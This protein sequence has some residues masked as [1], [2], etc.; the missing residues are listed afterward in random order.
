MTNTLVLETGEP[1]FYGRA[2][3]FENTLTVL[4]DPKTGRELYLIGTTNSSTLLAN[5]TKKLVSEVKPD[6]VIVQASQQWWKVAKN[7]NLDTQS[8]WNYIGGTI[9]REAYVTEN[10]P[11][12]IWFRLKYFLWNMTLKNMIGK[13]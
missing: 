11:R 13:L 8:E 4:K 6:E 9:S 3:P 2:T 1:L 5:R 10:N 12:G 7:I